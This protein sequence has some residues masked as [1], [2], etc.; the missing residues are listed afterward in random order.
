MAHR[1]DL[2]QRSRDPAQRS[3]LSLLRF[4]FSDQGLRNNREP[5][6]LRV[7]TYSSATATVFSAHNT[8]ISSGRARSLDPHSL[9]SDIF[10]K[11]GEPL[12][13][14]LSASIPF[15]SLITGGPPSTRVKIRDP[16]F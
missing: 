16:L 4:L 8:A 15:S 7:H 10:N 14:I 11:D 6:P 5:E 13:P 3:I 1:C 9:V 2:N 12:S